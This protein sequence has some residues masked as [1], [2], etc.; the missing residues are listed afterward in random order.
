MKTFAEFLAESKNVDAFLDDLHKTTKP[1][2]FNDRS[3]IVGD[4]DA[5]VQMYKVNDTAHLSDIQSLKPK[6]GAGTRAMQHIHG[7]ADKHGVTVSGFA[8]AYAKDKNYVTDTKKLK[9]WYEK[10]GYKTRKSD[11]AYEITRSPRKPESCQQI[12]ISKTFHLQLQMSKSFC[13]TL[14]MKT[15]K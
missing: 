5:M 10:M 12:T 1:H 8:N 14:L 11:D 9:S 4:N 6:S 7:L 3:R 13:R 2:P 15:F